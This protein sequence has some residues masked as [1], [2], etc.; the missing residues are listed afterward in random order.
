MT[1]LAALVVAY[2]V[3]AAAIFA[4]AI[5]VN[6]PVDNRTL[7]KALLV[8]ATWPIFIPIALVLLPFWAMVAA[9]DVFR[10]RL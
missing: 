6:I 10:W 2:V 9:S 1:L 4:V 3:V 5:L 7:G 8:A